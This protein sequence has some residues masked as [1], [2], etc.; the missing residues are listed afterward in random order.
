MRV[1]DLAGN[2]TVNGTIAVGFIGDVT[3]LWFINDG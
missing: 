2:A 1:E 3:V